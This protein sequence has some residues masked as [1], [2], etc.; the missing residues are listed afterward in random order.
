MIRLMTSPSYQLMMQALTKI[1]TTIPATTTV[2]KIDG[3]S[4]AASEWIRELLQP[5][6][7]S[8]EK[9]TILTNASFFAKKNKASTPSEADEEALNDLLSKPRPELEL[10]FL[11][12]GEVDERLS[13][14][15]MIQKHHEWIDLPL[16]KLEAWPAL[17]SQWASSLSLNLNPKAA[18]QLME[19]VFPDVDRLYQ[20][21]VKLS[22]YGG[23]I[24]DH[25][26]QQLVQPSLEENVF[27]LTNQLM[28]DN[29]AGALSIYRDFNTL[30]V[31]PTML[32]SLIA[33]HFQLY[34]KVL[35]LLNQGLDTYAVSQQLKIHEFRVR[36]MAQAKKRF[37]MHRIHHIIL[38]LDTL[39][40]QIKKG[41]REKQEALGWWL[42]NF[43]RA[44][45]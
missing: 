11:Y 24:D 2:E 26:V 30:Q 32:I 1:L 15:K 39:D 23:T 43:N 18:N 22:V 35:Y 33:K 4:L 40:E 9:I 20:E 7:W 12:Q 3:A 29:L 42:V 10:I 8:D 5:S 31:E 25:L 17:V 38:S 13:L 21:L 6:L 44:I 16:P 27:A 41:L 37:P 19:R 36:L 14:M 45:F 28:A 34:S